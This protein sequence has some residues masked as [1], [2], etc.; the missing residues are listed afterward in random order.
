MPGRWGEVRPLT[1]KE[2]AAT[3]VLELPL[4]EVSVKVRAAGSSE[5]PEDGEDRSVWAGVVL[6]HTV[7]GVPERSPLTDPALPLPGV[8]RLA[9]LT[10]ACDGCRHRLRLISKRVCRRGAP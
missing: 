10:A 8:C 6:A 1:A 2:L 4:D 9:A 5:D 3:T 7:V